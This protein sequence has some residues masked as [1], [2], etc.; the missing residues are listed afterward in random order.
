MLNSEVK[1][2]LFLAIAHTHTHTHTC[3]HTCT[4]THMRY[5]HTTHVSIAS[6]PLSF[7]CEQCS[8]VCHIIPAAILRAHP[9]PT[10]ISDYK[11]HSL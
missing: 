8:L 11:N 1:L 2:A 9:F 5:T 7:Y 6:K 10:S 3:T 4:H